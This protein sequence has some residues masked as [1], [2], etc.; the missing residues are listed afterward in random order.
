[1]ATTIT[2]TDDTATGTTL[3]EF[4]LEFLNERVTIRELIRA[5]VYQEV[6]ECNASRSEH[7]RGLV[8]PGGAEPGE[9]GYRLQQ[10]GQRKPP[11][12]ALPATSCASTSSWRSARHAAGPTGSRAPGTAPTTRRCRSRGE[13][14]LSNSGSRGRTWT[15]SLC[16][17]PV[18]FCWCAPIRSGSA[19]PNAGGSRRGCPTSPDRLLGSHARRRPVRRGL[20]CRQRC[21]PG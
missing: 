4:S 2:I 20:Q 3:D 15:T 14:P 10:S 5:C 11:R 16:P 18:S 6:T 8:Q 13:I 21:D 17:P 19:A 7:F 9:D 1:V 12:T